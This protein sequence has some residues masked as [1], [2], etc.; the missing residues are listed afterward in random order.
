MAQPLLSR[1]LPRLSETLLQNRTP[2][3]LHAL[4]AIASG[5]TKQ[6]PFSR[7]S[8][9]DAN[10]IQVASFLHK[11]SIHLVKMAHETRGVWEQELR[12]EK[13][14]RGKDLLWLHREWQDWA[15]VGQLYEQLALPED[16]VAVK[17]ALSS[18]EQLQLLAGKGDQDKDSPFFS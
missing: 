2:L 12:S 5:C 18:L 13:R 7:T 8:G 11:A 9:E 15:C 10:L 3:L 14:K 6:G 17:E 16:Q 4:I 1:F